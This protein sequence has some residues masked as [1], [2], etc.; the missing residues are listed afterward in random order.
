M[1]RGAGNVVCGDIGADDFEDRG[2]DVVVGYALDVAVAHFF[3][4]DLKG[5]G[6][7]VGV[8]GW[9]VNGDVEEEGKWGVWSGIYPMLYRM[10]RKPDCG[11]GNNMGEGNTNQ[12]GT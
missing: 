3:V 9:L 4:P 6:T 7:V 1:L 11:D 10:D 12:M 2:L 5:F 8:G